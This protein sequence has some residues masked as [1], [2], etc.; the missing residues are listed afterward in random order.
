MELA[1]T[2][3]AHLATVELGELREHHGMDGDV[4]AHAQRVGTAD[5]GQQTLLRKLFHQQAITRQHAGVMH[6][7]AATQQTLQRFAERR[8]E[9]R[10]LHG[11][12]DRLALLLGCHSVTCQV[13]RAGKRRIL[14]EMHDV[15]RAL[16][17]A[18]RK[19]NRPL[20][21]GERIFVG[22]RHRTRGV[23]DVR[24]IARG[25]A[26]QQI[27][28]LRNV[29]Q[30]G[31]HK[32]KLRFRQREQRHLPRPAAIGVAE[33]VKLVHGDAMD[34]SIRPF[35]QR[36]VRQ[37]LLGTADDGRLG[38]DMH[39]TRD[40]ANVVAAEELNQVEELLADQ[41]LDGRRVV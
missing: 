29:A 17:L 40:H 41:R 6:A 10:A 15:Q 20:E 1:A 36:L 7:H 35:A 23:G 34:E 3:T 5:D 31:A 30:R 4:D 22:K 26:A 24:D 2:Q 39:I 33:E 19:L 11:L 25:L 37:N 27:G 16:V 14:R 18:Q 13:L 38:V 21:R 9:L 12:L 28:D 32:Q 8:G